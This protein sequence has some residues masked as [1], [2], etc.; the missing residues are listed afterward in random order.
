[1][2]HETSFQD[3]ISLGEKTP[4]ITNLMYQD[5][6]DLHISLAVEQQ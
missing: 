1:M 4:L 5:Q 6:K 2:S 3:L